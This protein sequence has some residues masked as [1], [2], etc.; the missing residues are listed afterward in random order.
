[1]PPT[2]PACSPPTNPARRGGECG[3]EGVARLPPPPPPPPQPGLWS[4]GLWFVSPRLLLSVSLSLG[5]SRSLRPEA[6]AGCRDP[7]GTDTLSVSLGTSP[8][9]PKPS[10]VQ[11]HGRDTWRRQRWRQGRQRD[12]VPG[13]L[14]RAVPDLG[15]SFFLPQRRKRLSEGKCL[16]KVT[17]R[18]S[19]WETGLE[20]AP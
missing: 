20:P 14:P 19:K 3:G 9:H 5:L 1:M 7:S 8:P 13:L 6:Q 2:R 4:P 11:T 10:Q 15:A 18:G 12:S 16:A 17:R